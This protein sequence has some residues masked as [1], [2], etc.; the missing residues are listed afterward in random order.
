MLIYIYIYIE[1]SSVVL[2]ACGKHAS[3]QR[4]YI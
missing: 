2:Y 4:L 1:T 3:H